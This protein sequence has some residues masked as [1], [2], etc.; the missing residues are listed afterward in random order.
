MG[1]LTYEEFSN[2]V[3]SDLRR[4][5]E[6]SLATLSP[7]TGL[8]AERAEALFDSLSVSDREA[9][10]EAYILLDQYSAVHDQLCA[11]VL[12]A[13]TCSSLRNL[14]LQLDELGNLRGR[15]WSARNSNDPSTP[16]G[17]IARNTYASVWTHPLPEP[18]RLSCRRALVLGVGYLPGVAPGECVRRA[19]NL[20]DPTYKAMVFLCRECSESQTGFW[21]ERMRLYSIRGKKVYVREPE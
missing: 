16:G 1:A 8:P 4:S 20:E 19:I 15:A 3:R 21:E 12:S 2:S 9:I 10:S 17:K 11:D 6:Y 13:Q 18:A 5:L 14:A 7:A